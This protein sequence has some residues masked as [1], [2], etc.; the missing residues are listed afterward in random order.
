MHAWQFRYPLKENSGSYSWLM[1]ATAV[2]TEDYIYPKANSENRYAD[3]FLA[4]THLP[5]DDQTNF[6]QYGLYTP[7][8][9]WTAKDT[10]KVPPEM[11]KNTWKNAGSMDSLTAVDKAYPP[12][13]TD[14]L[15]RRFNAM[16]ER[17]WADALVAAW[18]RGPD[19]FF[20]KKDKLSSGAQVIRNT[21]VRVSLDGAPDK[22]YFLNDLDKSGKIE[23]PYLSARFYRFVFTDETVR[24]VVFYDGLRVNLKL[25]ADRDSTELKERN[26][27]SLASI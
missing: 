7:F 6:R 18:N 16:F 9:F 13:L 10:A 3:W 4:S 19:G 14:G 24:T 25:G 22:V 27:H 2:W 11:I 1:E 8:S 15:P 17:F 12:P 21:P 5:I 26:P 23:L 20:F